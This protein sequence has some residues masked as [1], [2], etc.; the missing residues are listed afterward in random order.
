MLSLVSESAV[1]NLQ[2]I[3]FPGPLPPWTKFFFRYADILPYATLLWAL[4]SALLLLRSNV[5]LVWIL[6]IAITFAFFILSVLL[7]GMI[8]IA[9]PFSGRIAQL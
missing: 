7:F 8:G 1:E 3:R 4:P 5:R 9:L 6:A 2:A